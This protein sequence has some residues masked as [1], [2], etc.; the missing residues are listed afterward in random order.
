MKELGPDW[1]RKCADLIEDKRK[2]ENVIRC[3]RCPEMDQHMLLALNGAANVVSGYKSRPLDE[4]ARE[5]LK[6]RLIEVSSSNKEGVIL[7]IFYTNIDPFSRSPRVVAGIFPLY[8]DHVEYTIRPRLDQHYFQDYYEKRP[9]LKISLHQ[10]S[11]IGKD[12]FL[13]LNPKG[14]DFLFFKKSPFKSD[15]PYKTILPAENDKYPHTLEP[16]D[17]ESALEDNHIRYALWSVNACHK[18][19]RLFK[20]TGF[21]TFINKNPTNPNYAELHAAFTQFKPQKQQQ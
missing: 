8:A 13:T 16:K 21:R 7:G 17:F 2:L 10:E 3:K 1:L 6:E 9:S 18:R 5:G 15:H 20:Q 12:P 19:P 4:A 11:L 14:P